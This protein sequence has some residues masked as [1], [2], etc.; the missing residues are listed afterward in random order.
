MKKREW[1]ISAEN[2][3][4]IL[5][6][7]ILFTI[8][9]R[10]VG[11]NKGIWIDEAAAIGRSGPEVTLESL[12]SYNHPPLYFILL[13]YWRLT[14]GD[15]EPVLRSL[16]IVF[17]ILTQIASFFWLK[18]K[19]S[20]PAALLAIF[21]IATLPFLFRYSQEIRHYQLLL[22]A[23]SG[24]FWAAMLMVEEPTKH[25]SY[26]ALS[27][28]LSTSVFTHLIGVFTLPMIA[29]Y[30]TLY[31]WSKKQPIPWVKLS[32]TFIFPTAAFFFVY[33]WFLT[34]A[35]RPNW[36]MQT[37]TF[38]LFKEAVIQLF[39]VKYLFFALNDFSVPPFLTTAY[40]LVII[41]LLLILLCC[42]FLGNWR[43]SLPFLISAIVYWLLLLGYSIYKTPIFGARL[44]LPTLL[45][46]IGFS[47]IQ[48]DTIRYQKAR[49]LGYAIVV[50]IGTISVSSWL[51]TDV[52]KPIEEWKAPADSLYAN[53]AEGDT[54]IF[55]PDYSSKPIFYYYPTL[56]TD[57]TIYQPELANLEA[58]VQT[59]VEDNANGGEETSTQRII[60]LVRQ[61]VTVQQLSEDYHN[62]LD[63]LEDNFQSNILLQVGSVILTEFQSP[64][65]I[66][67]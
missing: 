66:D 53:I 18:R 15:T 43:K 48:I 9:S 61:D 31:H 30:L 32:L 47:I 16:S 37:P 17:A 46:L 12:R 19:Q 58:T 1:V 56:Q 21:L 2:Y 6:A 65:Q 3:Q 42:L 34:N 27:V 7:I 8:M 23:I 14:F 20:V 64:S 44:L 29:T 57:N 59:I 13:K 67:E 22:L 26:F 40:G 10:F 41:G 24:A 49:K 5:F 45:P 54:I 50:I 39:G 60:L 4:W 62:A 52:N 33:A 11:I 28:L 36:W 35:V 38:A 55:Y 51:A 25:P 63:L